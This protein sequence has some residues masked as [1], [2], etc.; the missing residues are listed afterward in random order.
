[1]KFA[2][3]KLLIGIVPS[4]AAD[5]QVNHS[6]LDD[7]LAGDRELFAILAQTPAAAQPSQR[8]LHDPTL[9]QDDKAFGVVGPSDYV[10]A[11]VR[12]ALQPIVQVVVVVL[13]VGIDRLQPRE[14]PR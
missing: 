5:H 4:Q 14:R 1:M 10:Q 6:Y 12:V 11:V 2:V 9:R 8:T 3:A 7:G 13:A